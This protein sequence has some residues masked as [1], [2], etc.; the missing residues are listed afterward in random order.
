MVCPSSCAGFLTNPLR[1]LIHSPGKILDGYIHPGDT[2]LDFGCGPGYFTI[3]MARAVGEKGMVIAV[4]IQ[5][6]MLELARRAAERARVLPRVRFHKG[7]G[8]SLALDTPPVVSFALAFH[9]IH[10][11]TDQGSVLENIYRV[12]KPGG[13]LLLA[14]PRGV[15]GTGEF[16]ET[17][18]TAEGCG[19]T[20]VARPSILLSR[21]ILLRKG[22]PLQHQQEI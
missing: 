10:E 17:I 6:E 1:R 18:N 15:V 11:T 12:L 13:L 4:D 7:K 8:S 16:Q 22:D 5:G 14:E 20:P 3:P 2:V 9:V 19:F 21:S